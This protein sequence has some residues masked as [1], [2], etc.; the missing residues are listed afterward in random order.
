MYICKDF[1][2]YGYVEKKF[3]D[4]QLQ[5]I[6]DEIIKIQSNFSDAIRNND[7]LIGHIEK[8]FKLVD[9][10]D[11]VEKLISPMII[12]YE[13]RFGYTKS[14]TVN[15]IDLPIRLHSLWVNMMKKHEHNPVHNH[16]GV[17]SFVIWIDIPYSFEEE[18]KQAPEVT[19]T[20]KPSAGQFYFIVPSTLGHLI[21]REV[22]AEKNKGIVFP[23][24]FHHTVY[25]FYTSEGYRI[26]VSGNFKVIIPNEN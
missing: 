20:N 26:S 13:Q 18:I 23:A 21:V 25:P 9:C 3:T 11:H 15:S 24:D 14:I 17:F 5:P 19:K 7:K 2:N 22:P 10:F 1:E 4:E 6:R 12:A 8:E 16:T